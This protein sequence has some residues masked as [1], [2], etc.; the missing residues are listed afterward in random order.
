MANRKSVRK[1][2]NKNSLTNRLI[3]EDNIQ[4]TK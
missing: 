1:N 2:K 3:R 4:L